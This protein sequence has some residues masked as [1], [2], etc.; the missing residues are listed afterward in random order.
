MRGA[1]LNH[2]PGPAKPTLAGSAGRGRE[3]VRSPIGR[4]A[5][6]GQSEVKKHD[7]FNRIIKRREHFCTAG[8]DSEYKVLALQAVA[9]QRPMAGRRLEIIVYLIKV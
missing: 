2:R 6:N 8:R 9:V 4:T 3:A 1:F 5:A 7:L